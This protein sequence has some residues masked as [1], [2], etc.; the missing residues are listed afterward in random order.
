M[1]RWTR[2]ALAV[3]M[4]L[5]L[6]GMTVSGGAHAADKLEQ[7]K[8]QGYIRG[9]TA[10]EVPYGYMDADGNAAGIGPDVAKHVLT[11]MGVKDI[12]WVVTPFGSLIP[13]LKANRFDFVAAEQNI[14]PD[15]CKQVQFTTPEL[16]L[17][18]GFPG[19]GREPEKPAQL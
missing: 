14:L 11:S 6:A 19:K 12:E 7:V 17:W 3:A 4:G 8:Q 16:E 18:R 2:L 13:G 1:R 9:A 10:N 15:R 5:G